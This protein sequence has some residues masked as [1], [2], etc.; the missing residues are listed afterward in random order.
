MSTAI[1]PVQVGDFA[2]LIAR[3]IEV[4]GSAEEAI[5]WLETVNAKFGGLTPL[6]AYQRSGSPTIEEELTAIEHGIVA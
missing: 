4:F 6:Q 5:A 2:R 1:C 3:T